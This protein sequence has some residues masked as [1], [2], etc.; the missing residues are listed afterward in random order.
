MF[1]ANDPYRFICSVRIL[2]SSLNYGQGL[3][4]ISIAQKLLIISISHLYA[5]D[6]LLMVFVM[7]RGLDHGS[8][9]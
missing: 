7:V 3:K 8:L 2:F 5:K 4:P 1:M 9:A 6:P